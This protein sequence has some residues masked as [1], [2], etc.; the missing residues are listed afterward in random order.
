MILIYG[1][2]CAVI[3]AIAQLSCSVHF[4]YDIHINN[5]YQW[6]TVHFIDKYSSLYTSQS[7]FVTLVVTR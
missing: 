2:H 6:L 7:R 4:V 1:P 3:F 5:N